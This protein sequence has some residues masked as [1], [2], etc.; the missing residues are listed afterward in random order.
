MQVCG[1]SGTC[2]IG[3]GLCLCYPGYAGDACDVCAAGHTLYDG[4]CLPVSATRTTLAAPTGSGAAGGAEA[5]GRPAWIW[6]VI[7]GIAAV[8]VVVA[9]V[10]IVLLRRGSRGTAPSAA[11]PAVFRAG[12]GRNGNHLSEIQ[13][14]ETELP[15]G[16]FVLLPAS[17]AKGS[18][19]V[20]PGPRATFLSLIHI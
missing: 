7:G 4:R 13:G 17:A 15:A 3:Q 5:S 9:V 11:G 1:G 14:A 20:A 10:A 2:L 8:A 16:A 19:V 18:F 12:A 6:A